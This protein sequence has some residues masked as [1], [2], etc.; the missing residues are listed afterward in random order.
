MIAP[1][2]IISMT[3]KSIITT[4]LIFFLTCSAYAQGLSET[5]S[6]LKSNPVTRETLLDVSNK[7]GN[8]YVTS[9]NKD[10]AWIKVE[11]KAFAPNPAKLKKMF[12]GITVS[13]NESDKTITAHTDFI[14]NIN[15]LFEGFK[16]LT[17]KLISYES[18]M[19]IDYYINVPEY[20]N[21]KI[22]NKYGDVYIG[23]CTGDFSV[24][25]SNGSFKAGSLGEKSSVT[26]AF[27]DAS[28]NSV[29]S[30]TIEASFSELEIE[31][32][33]DLTITSTS[34]RYNIANAGEIRFESRRDKF[35][36]DTISSMNG[37]SYFTDFNVKYITKSINLNTKYGNMNADLIDPEFELIN[38]N[39]GYSD[40]SLNF[41]ETTSYNL[42]IRH[43][44]TFLI[45]PVKDIYTEQETLDSEKKEY[46]TSGTV[47]KNPGSAKVKIEATRGNIYLK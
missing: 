23:K 41:S 11:I 21:L 36:I 46:R 42:D 39:C 34:S 16:G 9:W 29:I 45:L 47:G 8:I 1:E 5:R 14:Q 15:N 20:L 2:K 32:S 37:N 10:S 28:I 4:G 30:G 25:I 17:N 19:E 13:I 6:Y 27:C 24:S 43:I 7:Y 3:C 40:I 12:D 38:L 33:K 44:N 31:K 18:R 22:N 35:F 26:M